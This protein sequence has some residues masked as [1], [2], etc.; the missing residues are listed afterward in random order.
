M[1]TITFNAVFVGPAPVTNTASVEWSS[2][3]IDPGLPLQPQSPYNI[4]STER[5]FN[6]L[7]QSVNNYQANSSVVLNQARGRLPDTGFA[8]GV[9]TPLRRMPREI[10]LQTGGIT[11]EIP[12]LKIN[13]PI[14]GVP[15]RNGDWNVSWL[16]AQAGWL[17][18]SSFPTWNG[19]S[20]L[21]SHVYLSN[22]LPGP[23]VDLGKLRYGEQVIVHAYGQKYTFEVRSNQVVAPND[24]SAFK[25]EERPW[26]TLVTC[27]E[28]DQETN[29]YRKRVIVRSVLVSV[30][31]E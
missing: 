31:D 6:P 15:L 19:N 17:E 12:A 10:Y 14:V 26:L 13:T 18:G 16:G 22:G 5:R 27:K 24:D 3:Q 28:Y 8:P 7:N 4:H 29:T 21:T 23:F 9:M 2:L 11:L 30:T 1:A 25:H 20:V